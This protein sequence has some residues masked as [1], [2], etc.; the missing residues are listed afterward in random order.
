[1]SQMLTAQFRS[2]I[3]LQNPLSVVKKNIQEVA[4]SLSECLQ[5]SSHLLLKRYQVWIDFQGSACE[6]A[7]AACFP[8]HSACIWDILEIV[9]KSLRDALDLQLTSYWPKLYKPAF[10]F[11]INLWGK[12]SVLTSTKAHWHRPKL[13]STYTYSISQHP[14]QY[15]IVFVKIRLTY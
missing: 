9:Q 3:P 10:E 4:G 5:T 1:M 8:V 6:W 14:S 13:T 12:K 11:P 2:G 15:E 7:F